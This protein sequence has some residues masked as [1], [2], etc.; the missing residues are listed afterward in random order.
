MSLG[1]HLKG[2][3]KSKW[4][5]CGAR[6]PTLKTPSCSGGPTP[7]PDKRLGSRRPKY[8]PGTALRA[9]DFRRR[10]QPAEGTPAVSEDAKRSPLQRT[11]AGG[12]IYRQVTGR[13]RASRENTRMTVSTLREK[14]SPPAELANT[15]AGTDGTCLEVCAREAGG[16]PSSGR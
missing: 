8:A 11:E 6:C 15:A 14:P 4:R 10:N 12:G 2:V 5:D 1:T 16:W 3:T 13:R 9:T 7:E